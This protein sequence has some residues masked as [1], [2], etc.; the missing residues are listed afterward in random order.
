[1]KDKVD[2]DAA[3][4]LGLALPLSDCE[5]IDLSSGPLHVSGASFQMDFTGS[6]FSKLLGQPLVDESKDIRATACELLEVYGEKAVLVASDRAT[7]AS[8]AR[9]DLRR[10]FWVSVFTEVRRTYPK[11]NASKAT[12]EPVEV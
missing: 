7:L 4:R 2:W 3:E 10:D 1:M 11:V 9:N 6:S 12:S 5:Q 8:Y